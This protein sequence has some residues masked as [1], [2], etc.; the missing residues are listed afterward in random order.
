ME[1]KDSYKP[2]IIFTLVLILFY[3]SSLFVLIPISLFN[4]DINNCDNTTLNLLRVFPNLVLSII[5][6][7]IYKKDL[8]KDFK[9]LKENFDSI[10]DTA[11]KYWLLGFVGMI[12]TNSLIAA[13]TPVKIATNEESIRELISITP[14]FSFFLICIFAPFVEEM[15]FRKS[16]KD[17]FKNKILFIITSG[18]VF[19]A[20]HVIGSIE[21]LYDLLYIIPYSILGIFFAIIYSKTDNIFSTILV[22]FTH[23]LI[24]LILNIVGIG[25]ILL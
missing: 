25:V 18:L 17:V 7:L 16:F 13:L 24:L 9:N 8:I 6:F 5:L 14:L 21:S 3:C 10:T 22:H 4:I 23:N 19:G 12:I 1:H 15:I 11:I 20:L 2:I